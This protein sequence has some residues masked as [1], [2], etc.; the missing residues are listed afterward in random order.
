MFFLFWGPRIMKIENTFYINS[1]S[2]CSTSVNLSFDFF[3]FISVWIFF[4]FFPFIF[5]SNGILRKF[6]IK[7]DFLCSLI[8]VS[9]LA[10]YLCVC[11]FVR[12]LWCANVYAKV[13]LWMCLWVDYSLIKLFF[14]LHPLVFF[15]LLPKKERK[16][17]VSCF[18]W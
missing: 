5:D 7:L 18:L 9:V 2:T 15:L 16:I 8:I 4:H 12:L 13:N 10:S 1:I 14:L 3:P 6:S 17:L 11:V